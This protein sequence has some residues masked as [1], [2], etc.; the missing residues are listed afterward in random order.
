M[1]KF[2]KGCKGIRLTHLCFADDLLVLCDGDVRSVRVL[3]EALDEFSEAS[4]LL[5]NPSKSTIF[6]GSL[7]E[8][9]KMEILNVMPFV[10]GKLPV[11]YL[12]VP[13]LTRSLSVKQCKSLVDKV[14]KRVS[15]WRN[16]GLSFARRLQLI[17]A[18]LSSIS[19]LVIC[20]PYPSNNYSRKSISCL[21]AFCGVKV[22]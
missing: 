13:L 2:H 3:K 15:D 16:K 11:K 22:N 7:K 19:L 1:F 5:P 8:S 20:F 17:S 10:V 4:G 21:R 18:V 14:V 9:E 12:G 6:F